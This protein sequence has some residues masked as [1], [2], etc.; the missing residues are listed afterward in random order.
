MK[1]FC[2]FLSLFLSVALV[3]FAEGVTNVRAQQKGEQIIITYDLKKT[4][5][6][7]AYI[8]IG[9]SNQYTELNDMTGNVG[10][11]VLCGTNRSIVWTP[12]KK[13]TEFI[14]QNVRFKIE[15]TPVVTSSFFVSPTKRVVFSPGNL[16]YN[17][18]TDT[19]R[20]ALHQWEYIGETNK[21]ILS[22]TYDGWI[23]LFGWG[24]S[25]YK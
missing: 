19:W 18:S 21:N 20:F 1:Q 22:K 7:R 4:S 23:D 15:A 6:V 8:A 10:K 25:M 14:A 17:A 9:Q 2:I 11:G 12:L 16:Q 13:Y 24:T 3:T 5:Y